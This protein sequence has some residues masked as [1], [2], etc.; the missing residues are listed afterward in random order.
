MD[1]G[2][3]SARPASKGGA[4][5]RRAH[6]GAESTAWSWEGLALTNYRT[7]AGGGSGNGSYSLIGAVLLWEGEDDLERCVADS[8]A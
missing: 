6:L 2:S 4:P 3:K 5:C 1:C 8:E 7:E